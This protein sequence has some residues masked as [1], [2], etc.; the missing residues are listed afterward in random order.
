[1]VSG[2]FWVVLDGS[3]VYGRTFFRVSGLGLG[4]KVSDF[5]F[6]KLL[7]FLKSMTMLTML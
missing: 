2:W 3:G 4:F 7:V 5:G 1:M 6:C